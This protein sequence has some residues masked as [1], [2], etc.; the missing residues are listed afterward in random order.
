MKIWKFVGQVV[1]VDEETAM[2][3]VGKVIN[4]GSGLIEF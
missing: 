4:Q 3:S 2:R 1:E